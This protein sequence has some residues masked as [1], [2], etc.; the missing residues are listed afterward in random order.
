MKEFFYP[1][2]VA[3]IGVSPSVTN[4]A[5]KIL[6]NLKRFGFEGPIYAIG[7]RQEEVEGLELYLSVTEVDQPID[8][9]ILMVPAIG[10]SKVV[11]QCGRKGIRHVIIESGGF[12]EFEG[13]D[14][15]LDQEL[16]EVCRQWGIRLIGPN[17]MG[18]I[19][20]ENG[21]CT[22][23]VT[24][25]D[26]FNPG[27]VSIISQSGGVGMS[28]ALDLSAE[29]VG[30]SKFV[31]YG[32]GLDIDEVD[33]IEYM[34]GDDDTTVISAYLE[35]I[36]RGRDFLRVVS[37][38][39]KPL[40]VLK[41]NTQRSAHLMAASHS[42]VLSGDE[43]ILD[44]AFK[45]VGVLRVPN[46]LVWTNVA[47]QLTLPL[48]KG[49]RLAILSRSGGHAVL[50]A[51]AAGHFGFKLPKF[52]SAFFDS[53][54]QH[55]QQASVI[56]LQNPLDLGQIFY[57]PILLNILEETLKLDDVDG[58]LL[59]HTYNSSEE[60]CDSA[61]QFL[62][63][64]LPLM[65]RY[66]KPVSTV[67]F[68]DPGERKFVGKTYGLPNF[69]TP[70]F[71]VQALAYSRDA[72]RLAERRRPF[73]VSTP[74][75]ANNEVK[76]FLKKLKEKEN[77]DMADV[78]ELM[79]LYDLRMA[80][81]KFVDSRDRLVDAGRQIGYPLALK[82]A[83]DMVL[84]K[85]DVGGVKL[86]IRNEEELLAAWDEMDLHVRDQGLTSGVKRALVQQMLNESGWELF[87]GAKRDNAFG[88][89]V[90]AGMGGVLTEVID[91]VSH[92]IAPLTAADASEMLEETRAIK[93]LE[94]FRRGGP[95]DTYAFIEMILTVSQMMMDID[96][97]AE[98]DLNPVIIHPAGQ[99]LT[100]LDAR[101]VL[102]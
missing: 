33:L 64:I 25:V 4:L 59:I 18:V 99:G 71:G 16:L 44:A 96:Q 65:E 47:K 51:D 31:S 86:N 35:G 101:I 69:T 43:D 28:C 78:F 15:K 8:L 70:F 72:L 67:L 63:Q 30:I 90:M 79:R 93:L 27:G 89:V 19:N 85:S 22:P 84:H 55:L 17:C 75:G 100:I 42:A 5:K 12:R 7:P 83:N 57:Q 10:V 76:D 9:A 45:Q 95:G 60:D 77:P 24:Y 53:Y 29:S 49:N 97:L 88:P 68:T 14:T 39:E 92:R 21:L 3:V 82:L 48:M 61:H 80:P 1:K 20:R 87:I 46:T 26:P 74:D 23:F 50:A 94:G 52:P 98:I 2:S 91:D 81:Y 36:K 32:N 73:D 38:M 58:A 56:N 13:S 11:E 54:R 40:V 62:S 34:A 37:R 6:Y 41:S 66:N 102:K